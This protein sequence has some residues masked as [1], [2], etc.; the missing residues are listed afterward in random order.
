[1]YICENITTVYSWNI[2]E[3]KKGSSSSQKINA[4]KHWGP[5][6]Y[7]TLHQNKYEKLLDLSV[8]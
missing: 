3:I 2:P 8:K 7:G 1:M 4:R 5:I 6:L